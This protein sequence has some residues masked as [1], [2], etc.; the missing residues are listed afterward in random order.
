[1]PPSAPPLAP[2]APRLISDP[3]AIPVVSVDAHLPG[4]DRDP[5]DL[6]VPA[7]GAT[8]SVRR[9]CGR[10]GVSSATV[11]LIARPSPRRRRFW[12]LL[13]LDGRGPVVC[14]CC[15]RLRTEHLRDHAGQVSFPGGRAEDS[16]MKTPPTRRLREAEEEVGLARS[17]VQL[18]EVICA[19]PTYAT[20]TATMIVTPV[21]GTVS[22]GP[23]MALTLDPSEVAES[24]RGAA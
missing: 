21:V 14:T 19:L 12:Y 10:S 20:V 8:L 18:L 13:L 24:V 11:G 5:I 22:P 15:S 9:R 3:R 6:A 1:M 4:I 2:Q 7:L 16:A 23:S 17:A